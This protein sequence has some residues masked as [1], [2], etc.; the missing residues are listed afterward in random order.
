MQKKRSTK[1]TDKKKP[2][3]AN[4]KPPRKY[5]VFKTGVPSVEAK[6][7]ASPI[8]SILI[9]DGEG[10]SL[11]EIG[12]VAYLWND[13]GEPGVY[14]L[15]Q[16]DSFGKVVKGKGGALKHVMLGGT[17]ILPRPIPA[18]DLDSA[19]ELS[20]LSALVK[21][22]E[23]V[24]RVTTLEA[25]ALNSVIR[26]SGIDAPPDP[27]QTPAG[28]YGARAL[29]EYQFSGTPTHCLNAAMR[30]IVRSGA[31]KGVIQPAA[32]MWSVL[33]A[34]RL[35]ASKRRGTIP[36]IASR[37]SQGAEVMLDGKSEMP[38][39]KELS[40]QAA[41]LL[42][43]D[44]LEV[45]LQS[46]HILSIARKFASTM[47]KSLTISFRHFF[48]SLL[49][50]AGSEE[51][52]P[53]AEMMKQAGLSPD[54]LPQEF[55][56]MVKENYPK[57]NFEAWQKFFEAESEKDSFEF[58]RADFL[59][60]ASKG[61]DLL[62]IGDDVRALAALVAAKEVSP[63]L[64]IGLFGDWGSGKTFFMTKLRETVADIAKRFRGSDPGEIAFCRGIVQIEFNAW[65]YMDTN[66]WA[67]LVSHIF[68]NL[69]LS[70]SGKDRTSEQEDL[71][72]K[73]LG[74]LRSVQEQMKREEENR[75]E[76]ERAVNRAKTNLDTQQS[77]YEARR[78]NLEQLT[79]KDI[80]SEIEFDTSTIERAQKVAGQLGLQ[81]GDAAT[82][83]VFAV[84]E[85]LKAFSGSARAI[86][87]S[88]ATRLR[89]KKGRGQ[90]ISALI[91]LLVISALPFVIRQLGV[92]FGFE[93]TFAQVIAAVAAAGEWLRRNLKHAAGV[94]NEVQEVAGELLPKLEDQE[95]IR[96]AELDT[97]R[98]EIDDLRRKRDDAEQRWQ[99][100]SNRKDDLELKLRRTEPQERLNTFLDERVTSG[101][102]RK[103]L[104]LLSTIRRDFDELWSL[105]EA[106]ID[107]ISSDPP[108]IKRII[109]Y[110]DD[111]DRCP[112]ERVVEVLQAVHLL[113]ALPLFVV[114][115]AVD[116]RWVARSLRKKYASLLREDPESEDE[117]SAEPEPVVNNIR[118]S[119]GFG[120]ASAQDY[121]EKI[122]QIPFWL[123]KMSPLATG[124]LMQGVV[125]DKNLID[126]VPTSETPDAGGLAGVDGGEDAGGAG[127]ATIET[128]SK[129]PATGVFEY[130]PIAPNPPELRMHKSELNFM[131]ELAGIAGRSPRSVKRFVNI[132]RLL[133]VSR[134][135]AQESD[136]LKGKEEFKA[137]LLL[138]AVLTGRIDVSQ[139]F[140]SLLR[141]Q[142]G[143]TLSD[144]TTRIAGLY[145]DPSWVSFHRELDA[146]AKRHGS[147][148][149]VD[150]LQEWLPRAARFSFREWRDL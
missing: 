89:D 144:C 91:I 41:G 132:Y 113:L 39:A 112:H 98:S 108:P 145:V 15:A 146:F 19:P 25:L 57:D 121:L 24:T 95:R 72:K 28:N 12:D 133:K 126:D 17:A 147:R 63:P 55:L 56:E 42:I 90:L 109:L 51:G 92:S 139:R 77:E 102:Y 104:G 10:S 80:W 87:L 142:P 20:L 76:L 14:A 36:F 74:D 1:A 45:S 44:E 106:Q 149:L 143:G 61:A 27:E 16:V 129:I 97:L 49:S 69:Y 103:R 125:G 81:P 68:D 52:K 59:S 37:I 140:V 99:Q 135:E 101:E 116:S 85:D 115:V 88:V 138:L 107:T 150:T 67:S 134:R 148:I 30:A 53:I 130:E 32:L 137:A 3:R 141:A 62:D 75:K 73:I 47:S 33:T 8:G 94:M 38:D 4:K 13:S 110:I 78:D 46:L 124:R 66:L 26:E 64:A 23:V 29:E 58:Q 84:A 105:L 83:Q 65:N 119:S 6:V 123:R 48:A 117:P 118:P 86:W 127:A 31:F 96:N 79:A 70:S 2:T 114:V 35:L 43:P 93:V 131:K 82:K 18:L 34:A 122:F 71:K 40:A 111:L 60:D 136:F 22:S 9:P 50:F 120:A 7:K 128:A 100:L 21:V 54:T 5:W 11:I